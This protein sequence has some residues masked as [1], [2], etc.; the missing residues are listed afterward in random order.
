[1]TDDD[2]K[3]I[4]TKRRVYRLPEDARGIPIKMY[5]G[6]P[7]VSEFNK[8][9]PLAFSFEGVFFVTAGMT[10]AIFSSV[11]IRCSISLAFSVSDVLVFWNSTNGNRLL[12][13]NWNISSRLRRGSVMA[14]RTWFP[15]I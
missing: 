6:I 5:R 12:I 3:Y 9:L 11:E 8:A 13:D 4:Y 14:P 1:M 10:T 2:Y 15:T 7:N